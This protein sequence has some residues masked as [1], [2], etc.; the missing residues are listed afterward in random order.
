MIRKTCVLH[1]LKNKLC[2]SSFQTT[3]NGFSSA[4]TN[5]FITQ[6]KVS[7]DF[8]SS[9]CPSLHAENHTKGHVWL[10]YDFVLQDS[11][12]STASSDLALTN[13][14]SNGWSHFPT[15]STPAHENNWAVFPPQETNQTTFPSQ[16]WDIF[17]EL[18]PD[19][20]STSHL[21]NQKT[22]IFQPF[23][24]ET[25][26]PQEMA[27]ANTSKDR[28]YL[29]KYLLANQKKDVQPVPSTTA[30]NE[31]DIFKDSLSF[32]PSPAINASPAS[33]SSDVFQTPESR[34]QSKVFQTIQLFQTPA[35]AQNDGQFKP[36]DCLA[37]KMLMPLE[38]STL[39]SPLN[40]PGNGGMVG[41]SS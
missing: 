3:V 37:D 12:H 9:F 24:E 6:G 17:Q 22:N 15:P 39:P 20:I 16:K 25:S 21:S 13:G 34:E 36:Q 35:S 23:K 38:T 41:R 11:S 7:Y 29:L 31:L 8:L 30:S 40:A 5:P 14:Q 28:D 26:V 32:L 2:H 27:K 1:S 18:Y 33:H 4:S 10:K 19:R